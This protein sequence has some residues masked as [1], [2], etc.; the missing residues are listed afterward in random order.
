MKL[1]DPFRHSQ[2]CRLFKTK[3]V[4]ARHSKSKIKMLKRQPR[5]R[6]FYACLKSKITQEQ[7]GFTL[8][9]VLV[10]IVLLSIIAV[11]ILTVAASSYRMVRFV[12]AKETAE[13]YAE[14]E[15]EY[16]KAQPYSTSN[17]YT[18]A[19]TS[20]YPSNYTVQSIVV[21][22]NSSQT[23]EQQ[24]TITVAGNGVTYTLSDNKVDF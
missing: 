13:N 5:G 9:E 7:K 23:G 15:M 20:P 16:I 22:P 3:I 24:I 8:V 17:Q 11:G 19:S 2:L 14:W 10:A 1:F 12:D 4:C 21:V 18:A 6:P